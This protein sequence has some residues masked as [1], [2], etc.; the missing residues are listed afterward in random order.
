M[1]KL[2]MAV[3]P[4]KYELPLVISESL[5]EIS[6]KTGVKKHAILSSICHNRSGKNTGYKFLRI[7]LCEFIDELE[8]EI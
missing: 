8:G 7:E 4:D 6:I 2:Y 1:I 3:T 5:D